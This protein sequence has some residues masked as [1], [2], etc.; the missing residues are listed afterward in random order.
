MSGEKAM[1]GTVWQQWPL[2]WRRAHPEDSQSA[3]DR[4]R[5]V[6]FLR[7]LREWEG[8]EWHLAE[9]ADELAI[10]ED[11]MLIELDRYMQRPPA[12]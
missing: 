5:A 7:I 4:V 2:H 11:E 10:S 6:S 3:A 1:E 8:G 12:A 9:W